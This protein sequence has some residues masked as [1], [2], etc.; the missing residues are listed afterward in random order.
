MLNPKIKLKILNP[1]I[2]L[3]ILNPKIKLKMFNPK[4]KFNNFYT[5]KLKDVVFYFKLSFSKFPI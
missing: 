5:Q 1:K 4:I 2:K 3:K